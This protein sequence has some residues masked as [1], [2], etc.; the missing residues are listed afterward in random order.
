M[1]PY[2]T[3]APRPTT[4]GTNALEPVCE[5]WQ[6][7]SGNGARPAVLVGADVR[8]L[9]SDFKRTVAG[10]RRSRRFNV[11]MPIQVEAG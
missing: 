1:I 11:A 6:M 3:P 4:A 2:P 9:Y 5:G 7:S 10:A 8:R